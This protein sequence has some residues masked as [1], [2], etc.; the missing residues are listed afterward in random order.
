MVLA[1]VLLLISLLVSLV[2][3]ALGPS[4]RDRVMALALIST[5]GTAVLIVLAQATDTPALRD[6]ALA[7][8]V[9][10]AL[11]V[12]VRIVD[13]RQRADAPSSSDAPSS[14]EENG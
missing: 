7:L 14:A 5:T 8:T 6:A 11:V 13:E 10:A 4:V 9:V 12:A 1:S 2:R 3:V